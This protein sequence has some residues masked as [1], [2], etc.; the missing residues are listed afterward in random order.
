MPLLIIKT[1]IIKKKTCI[2]WGTLRPILDPFLFIV[3]SWDIT[4]PPV[5]LLMTYCTVNFADYISMIS[6]GDF[7]GNLI[8][9][10]QVPNGKKQ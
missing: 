10:S 4:K 2:L 9:I 5:N 3:L 6:W 1:K 7:V 8:A